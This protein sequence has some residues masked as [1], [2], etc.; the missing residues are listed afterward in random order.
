MRLGKIDENI[1]VIGNWYFPT[2]LIVGDKVAMIDAGVTVMGPIY[3]KEILSLTPDGKIDFLLLTHSH[4]DHCGAIPYLRRNLPPFKVLASP[5]AKEV[6]QKEKAM[7]HIINLNREVEEMV[8]PL[9]EDI[10][11]DRIDVDLELRE[12]DYID[13]GKGL[14]VEVLETPG[15]TRC[16][17]SFYVPSKKAIFFGEAGGVIEKDGK[18]KPQ[19]LSSYNQYVSSIEKMKRL[20]IEIIG[21]A[22]G[23]AL[24]GE[25]AKDY[26]EKS[27]KETILFKERIV[28]YFRKYRDREKVIEVIAEEDFKNASQTKTPYLLNLR[29]S[30]SAIEKE[31]P[32]EINP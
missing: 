3:K 7:V 32:S 18:I 10:S 29:A 27:L 19:F 23:G 9:R 24:I 8:P 20:E 15:H 28:E 16:G 21:L 12:G 17:L 25:E 4:F 13:L 30:V 31:F 14:K 26:L 5:V 2:Y 1:F 22:H 11:I 6:F